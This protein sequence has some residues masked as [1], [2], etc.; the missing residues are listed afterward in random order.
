VRIPRRTAV[1]AGAVFAATTAFLAVA[2]YP[3][4]FAIWVPWDDEGYFLITLRSFRQLG[5]LYDR[6]FTYYGPLY[7]LLLDGLF[8]ALRLPITHDHGRLVALGLWLA[9]SLACGMALARLAK[10]VWI[11]CAVQLVVFWS[12]LLPMPFEALH[13]A[14]LLTLLLAGLLG[15][16][17]LVPRRPQLALA[18]QG[19]LVAALALIKINVGVFALLAVAFASVTAFPDLRR[20]HVLASAMGVA[21]ALAPVALM[22]ANLDEPWVRSYV[23]LVAA[24]AAALAVTLISGGPVAALGSAPLARFISCAAATGVAV[25]AL[26]LARGTTLGGLIGALVV[27]PFRQAGIFTVPVVLPPF[28]GEIALLLPPAAV[29]AARV[30]R[31]EP[32]RRRRDGPAAGAA[33]LGRLLVGI[34]MGFFATVAGFFPAPF[35]WIAAARPYG[36][37]DSPELAYARH[38]L[39]SLAVLQTLHAYPVGG[40]HIPWS[41][42]LLVPVAAICIVDGARQLAAFLQASAAGSSILRRVALVLGPAV[43]LLL[44]ASFY[45]GLEKERALY[46]TGVPLALPGTNRLH[47]P[48]P[49]AATLVWLRN[50]ILEHCTMFVGL[51]GL[52][53]FYFWTGQEPPNG[54]NVGT[55]MYLFPPEVQEGILERIRG[56]DRLCVVRNQSLVAMWARGR[57]LPPG[58]LVD[59]LAENFTPIASRRGYELL[60]RTRAAEKEGGGGAAASR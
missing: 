48:R 46:R 24:S 22:A 5:A 40:S 21:I 42:F 6:V 57:P 13:P 47:L 23:L 9:T 32:Q 11:G 3:R 58:P 41:S 59:Y 60:V 36:S 44:A 45:Q 49:T 37:S 39:P 51:P 27:A 25:F 1:L 19:V 18:L 52:P 56:V 53:S 15:T 17:L 4:M 35:A 26:I 38:L 54:F 34:A 30:A 29:W 20:R 28:S 14:G 50:G 31:R 10:S 55:W 16:A 8:A 43:A 33:G 2:S 7:Y 12:L